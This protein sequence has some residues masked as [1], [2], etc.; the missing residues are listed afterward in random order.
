L[1]RGKLKPMFKRSEG[2]G[3][4]ATENRSLAS[5]KRQKTVTG[6]ETR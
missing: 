2:K 6:N 3:G 1:K 4:A 5:K